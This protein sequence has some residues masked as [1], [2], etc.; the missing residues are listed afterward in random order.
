[1]AMAMILL[2]LTFWAVGSRQVAFSV[3]GAPPQALEEQRRHGK[4]QQRGHQHGAQG[5]HAQRCG[6]EVHGYGGQEADEG[7]RGHPLARRRQSTEF[8]GVQRLTDIEQSSQTR[9]CQGRAREH[10]HQRQ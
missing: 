5:A 10:Q 3:L 4:C 8:A 9:Q 2:N 6:R 1:M 7:P